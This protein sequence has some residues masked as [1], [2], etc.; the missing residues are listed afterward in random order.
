MERNLLCQHSV[1]AAAALKLQIPQEYLSSEFGGW[2]APIALYAVV[3]DWTLGKW[4][5]PFPRQ[6]IAHRAADRARAACYTAGQPV[7]P[8]QVSNAILYF[9]S[10]RLPVL[11]WVS[12]DL[13][14][15]TGISL[16]KV[17][18]HVGL[19]KKGTP[20]WWNQDPLLSA[21]YPLLDWP[22]ACPKLP[23]IPLIPSPLTY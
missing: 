10:H 22:A 18:G 1:S 17:K 7:N 9:P 14:Q 8:G 5:N 11:Q 19:R 2:G 15:A 4:L 21:P 13:W 20:Y 12:L 23:R 16:S 6:P 3:Q